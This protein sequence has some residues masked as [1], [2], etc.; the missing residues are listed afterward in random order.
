M[1]LE[2]HNIKLIFLA[3]LICG[4]LLLFVLYKQTEHFTQINESDA[5]MT[6]INIETK[7]V[8]KLVVLFS[9]QYRS[10]ENC[11]NNHIKLMNHLCS[12]INNCIIGAHYW[13]DVDK[14]PP[15]DMQKLNMKHSTSDNVAND[16]SVANIQ[17][18]F[19]RFQYSTKKALDNAEQLYFEKFKIEMPVNQ[20]ILRL[21]P[22]FI[23]EDIE[24]FP[25]PPVNESNYYIS[26]WN[27]QHRPNPEIN[28]LEITDIFITDKASLLKIL[29][30]DIE[31]L[32]KKEGAFVEH[33][34]YD[35]LKELKIQILYDFNIKHGAMLYDKYNIPDYHK[36]S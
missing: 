5:S 19:K 27:T 14:P 20:Q 12:D 8:D 9:T 22:D 23:V 33:V 15:L 11:S 35:M 10:W 7:K 21:R 1:K 28:N 32:K 18:W 3:L 24:K 25:L 31:T 26:T 4:G 13:N 2:R 17:K 29:Q 34:F 36:F 6:E 30:F 16:D